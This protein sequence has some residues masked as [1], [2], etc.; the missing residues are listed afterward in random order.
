M[1]LLLVFFLVLYDCLNCLS[2]MIVWAFSLSF[3]RT[4]ITSAS[5]F[6]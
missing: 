1:D 4:V 2:I 6:S 3:S 5:S